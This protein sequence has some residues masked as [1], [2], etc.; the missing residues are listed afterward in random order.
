MSLKAVQQQYNEALAKLQELDR[1]ISDAVA[2]NGQVGYIVDESSLRFQRR[3]QTEVVEMHR[4]SLQARLQHKDELESEI[5]RLRA[6]LK[7][8]QP[9]VPERLMQINADIAAIHT[10]LGRYYPFLV[11]QLRN[12]AIPVG[13]VLQ[14]YR[15]LCDR[16][17]DCEK[18]LQQLLA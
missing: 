4:K 11:E 16:L 17:A 7:R 18:S 15:T 5:D 12:A 10:A 13:S 14:Q 9:D 2:A 1:A 8:W 3:R 6:E